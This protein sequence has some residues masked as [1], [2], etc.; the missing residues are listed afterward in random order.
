M[1]STDVRQDQIHGQPRTRDAVVAA[2]TIGLAL[3]LFAMVF[4]S[5][6]IEESANS[7][8]SAGAEYHAESSQNRRSGT[9]TVLGV[10]V[11]DTLQGTGDRL[12]YQSSWGQSLTWPLRFF[13][14]WEYYSLVRSLLFSLP[15]LYLCLRVLQSWLP[16]IPLWAML[17]FGALTNSSYGLYLR[18][19]EWSDHYVQTQGI[20]AVALFMMHRK[21]HDD[22]T[23]VGGVPAPHL[24][25]CLFV[26]LN[27]VL[28]G[29]PGYWP[30]AL[31]V[32]SSIFVV[33]VIRPLFRRNI[34]GWLKQQ[35]AAVSFTAATS[36]LLV[37]TVAW[38]LLTEMAGSDWTAGRLSR[39][40]GLFSQYVFVGVYGLSDGGALPSAMRQVISSVIA[41]TVMPFFVLFDGALPQL[42]RASSFREFPRVEFSGS[43]ILIGVALGWRGFARTPLRQMIG[44]IIVAQVLMWCSVVASATD[45]VPTML[46]SSGAW[47]TLPVVLVVNVF[48]SFLVIGRLSW[49]PSLSSAVAVVNLFLTAYWLLI[50]LGFAA[51]GAVLQ[52]PDQ[53]PSRFRAVDVASES[54]WVATASEAPGRIL[55]A[56]T[57]SLYDSLAFLTLGQ[58]VVAP[59]DPKM[60]S[61]GQLQRNFAFNFSINP[62]NFEGLTSEEINRTLE[63]LQVRYLLIGETNDP[64]ESPPK[65]TPESL[66]Q[67]LD[68]LLEPTVVRLPKVSYQTYQRESFAVFVL[69]AMDA[70]RS[71][72]CAVLFE[73]CPVVVNSER[74]AVSGE[75]QLRMCK[76]HC[77]WTFRA[78]EVRSSDVLIMPITFDE[79]LVVA[80]SSGER[81]VTTSVGGFLGVSSADGLAKD[82][83]TVRLEPD[84]R[85]LARVI[86]SYLS[87]GTL[88]YLLV[89][90][91]Y[92]WMTSRRRKLRT[93]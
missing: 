63:F 59:A 54:N 85:M 35:K 5:A 40:P 77:L 83:L 39:T 62:P 9:H 50:Q 1:L 37:G 44:R 73:A 87:L 12:P 14:G 57:P 86:L 22:T 53:H 78:P 7:S 66:A 52:I 38:D 55:M 18:Q 76:Q 90:I 89:A 47:M 20:C 43:L 41:T 71:Q 46:A 27:G 23:E 60:R 34:V 13:V 45:K 36:A 11:F 61:S 81:L 58:P 8:Y 25:V 17:L 4:G 68:R 28:A 33:F 51:F 88:L 31:F 2:L 91:S 72:T 92:P 3:L 84:M 48:L 65:A 56:T 16:R 82:V 74:I 49:R 15:A 29:H 69:S 80:D 93:E 10:P 6:D 70:D 32:W 64:G 79:S 24:L 19:N 42:L 75:P 67:V 21:F 26:A 30:L